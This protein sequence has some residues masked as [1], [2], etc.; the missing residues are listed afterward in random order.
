[1]MN[2]NGNG[3][4]SGDE[5]RGAAH[6]L[7]AAQRAGNLS[8][9]ALKHSDTAALC[10]RFGLSEINCDLIAEFKTEV[11]GLVR[12]DTRAAVQVATL[13]DALAQLAPDV[14]AQALGARTKGMALHAHAHYAEA[15]AQYQAAR[16]LYDQA[17]RPVDKARVERALVDALIY[18]GRYDEALLIANTARKVLA[19]HQETRLLA[20]LESNVGNLFHRLDRNREALDCYQ[21]AADYFTQVEDRFGLALTSY[22]RANVHCNLDEFREAQTLY[23]QSLVL[24]LAAENLPHAVRTRY[25]LGY[26]RFLRGAYHQALRTMQETREAALQIGDELTAALCILDL[27][28]IYL[29]LNALDEAAQYGAQA[30]RQFQSFGMRYEAARAITFVGLA[31]LRQA[32]LDQAAASFQQAHDAFAA[33]GNAVH[34]GLIQLYQAETALARGEYAQAATLADAAAELFVAQ[35]LR[36][37][38]CLALLVKARAWLAEGQAV[39]YLCE[40]IWAICQELEMPWLHAQAAETLGDA[41]LAEND[42]AAAHTHYAAAI[43]SIEQIRSQIGA[44]EFRSSFFSNKLGIYEKLVRLCLDEADPAT[45]FY[46]LESSKARGL[47]DLLIN[48]LEMTT[49]T[50]TDAAA[51][52]GLIARWHGLRE[53]LHWLNHKLRKAE[54]SGQ[55]RLPSTEQHL[56]AEITRCETAFAELTR[57]LEA[58]DPEFLWRQRSSGVQ[59]AELR[60]WLAE[61]EAIIKYHSDDQHLRIFVIERAG[62]QEF[63]SPVSLAE[64]Q[65]ALRGWG[66]LQDKFHLGSA[67]LAH[68]DED[69]QADTLTSLHQL[70]HALFAPIAPHLEGKQLIFIPADA[71][72]NVPFQAL[73]DGQSYLLEDHEITQLPSVRLL[74]QC[75]SRKVRTEGSVALFGAANQGTPHLSD[76]IAALRQVFPEADCFLGAL[77]TSQA[78]A[79]HAPGNGIL[80]IAA[81]LV[82]RQDNPFF[83]TFLWADAAMNLYDLGSLKWPA[84]LVTLS[85]CGTSLSR[86]QTGNELM[87]LA[88]GFLN[89]GASALLVNLWPI[90]DEATAPLL[91]A[92]YQ[93]VKA[94]LPLRTA[95]RQAALATKQQYPHPYFWS[96][97]I[98]ISHQPA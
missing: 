83:S 33:E 3:A 58:T 69:W 60:E 4:G 59:A 62:L 5:P 20:Q 12:S 61:D 81:Q 48:D 77:V 49:T 93:H 63:L 42:L 88:Q 86:I 25:S 70:W 56:R 51:A 13:A 30:R 95:L 19:E 74:Q 34:L 67:A 47:M 91:A 57:S 80:H 11:D 46:Y 15:V 92:F 85:G 43:A 32:S 22:N 55:S 10:Q 36:A 35:Q 78:F 66:A 89:T 44:D 53:E 84:A 75:A 94:G 90:N 64:I 82:L 28:E 26:L 41:C 39:R 65:E 37:K 71:L 18:L 54:S 9:A 96:P 29:Q 16:R 97:F 23:Q 7:L 38:E 72:H 98:L 14:S 50:E 68:D 87:G 76:E 45:A 52:Q 1:M 40:T 73:F 31:Q 79:D 2:A 17:N 6:K 24:H 8:L 27:A 21:R